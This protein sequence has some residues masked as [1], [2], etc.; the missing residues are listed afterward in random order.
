DEPIDLSYC[1]LQNNEYY[2]N[3]IIPENYVIQSDSLLIIT[4]R[5]ENAEFYF[6]DATVLEKY[7]YDFEIGDNLKIL[8]PTLNTILEYNIDEFTQLDPIGELI[9]INEINYNSSDYFDTG[10][11]VELY[12]YGIADADLSG[13]SFKDDSDDHIFEIPDGTILETDSYLILAKTLA[14]FQALFPNVNNSIGDW[15]FGLSGSGEIARLFNSDDI[16]IDVVEYLDDPPWPNEADGDGNTLELINPILDNTLYQ[17]WLGSIDI[18]GTPGEQ[19]SVYEVD[20]E[21]DVI[22]PNIDFVLYPNPFHLKDNSSLNF[23]FNKTNR[24]N[25]GTINIYNIR[26]Q[27]VKSIELNKITKDSN[28]SWDGKNNHGKKVTSGI[29]FLDLKTDS[30]TN[31]TKKI[32]VI[33]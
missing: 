30:Q 21:N 15:G 16:L 24:A 26:G 8:S 3:F 14:D 17:S 6:P 11:W 23:K 13:W 2:E 22:P 20:N 33:K 31:L 9:V 19:N 18:G 5:L 7:Y 12:N 4:N 27:K 25:S 28:Y 1:Y 29:Y 10:D 32:V